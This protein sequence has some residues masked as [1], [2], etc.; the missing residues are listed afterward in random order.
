MASST[1]S[2]KQKLLITLVVAVLASTILVSTISQ[3]IAR[4]LVQENVEQGQLPNMVQQVANR[5]DKEVSVMQTVAQSIA[6]NPDMIAWSVAG[7]DAQGEQRLVKYLQELVAYN[8]LEAASFVDRQTR[9]YWNQDGFLRQLQ[10][11]SADGWFFAYRDSGK[12]ESLSLYNEGGEGYRLFANYQQVNGRGMSGVAKSVDELVNILN[13]VKIA[14]SGFVYMVDGSGTIIAHPDTSLLGQSTLTDVTNNSA[15]STLLS[16]NNFNMTS[17]EV[18]GEE[19][20]LA[21]SFIDSAGWYVVAQV[22]DAE[23]YAGLDS[24]SNHIIMWAVVIAVIFALIGIWLASS[25][26]RPI[27]RLADIF[28]NLGKGEGDL[29]TR[30]DVPQQKEIGR[31]VDGFNQFIASLHGT[32]S[33]VA[34]TSKQLRESATDVARSSRDSQEN[35]K[36]QRDHT[37]QVATALNQMGSTVNEVAQSAQSAAMSAH[38]ANDTSSEGRTLTRDAVK[39]IERLSDQVGKVAAVIQSLDEHTSAI[40]SI[41]DTIRGIS[42]QTN[43]LA[44]NAAIEAAR[45]GDHGRGFSVVADEVRTL[46]QR[47]ASATDEIQTKIDKF[48]EDSRQAVNQMQQSQSQTDDV[49]TVTARIDDI[50]QQI[51]TEIAAINDVNTQVA[52]ATE[53][54]SVVVEDINKNIHEISS[55]SEDSLK[56][57]TA[58]VSVSERLDTLASELASQVSRFK[59]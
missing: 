26:T 19:V 48:Q 52:T 22:P 27:E 28:Q 58:M 17:T 36:V 51:A 8:K 3:W 24:A 40:G 20:L 44:L 42:E 35:S 37:I 23:I 7:A 29:T 9:K 38:T 32:I 21:S 59:L 14:Q 34:Q 54:Q 43:L 4:D 47:A 1:F 46:A 10:E 25:I 53:E 55:N 6:T 2:I 12:K 15:S 33:T 5:V 56:A 16:K 30:I 31:L 49:V 13:S 18:N 50:L 57:A 41:L 11:G 39:A 45:A